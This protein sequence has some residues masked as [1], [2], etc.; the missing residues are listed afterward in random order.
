LTVNQ[1]I[2]GSAIS[3][4]N[5][6]PTYDAYQAPSSVTW[7]SSTPLNSSQTFSTQGYTTAVI[8]LAPSG[9][10]TAGAITFEVFDGTNWL[11]IKAAR[12]DSYLTDS[13]V[14]LA[15]IG[16]HSWQVGISGFSQFRT[17]LSTSITGTG[18]VNIVAIVSAAT[19]VSLVTVGFD[20]TQPLPA[21]TNALGSVQVVNGFTP[22]GNSGPGSITTA[23]ADQTILAANTSRRTVMVQNQ[24]TSAI[25]YVYPGT[26]A[27]SGSALQG[28]QLQPGQ[29]LVFDVATATS[30]FHAASATSGCPYFVLEG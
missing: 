21:G 23:N 4:S 8:T 6:V 12:T 30:A 27:W 10:I 26:A 9:T 16:T 25:L 13:I 19:D 29:A 15:G 18:S 1:L 17:R 2:G 28:F 3:A 20:P 5:A 24:H 22:T 11:A 14:Q 7:S